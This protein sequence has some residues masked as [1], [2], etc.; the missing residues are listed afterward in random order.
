[1]RLVSQLDRLVVRLVLVALAAGVGAAVIGT[2]LLA[3]S[4]RQ[5]L[6][7]DV[8][9]QHR[10]MAVDVATRSDAQID[11]VVSTLEVVATRERIGVLGPDSAGELAAVLRVSDRFDELVLR[12]ISGAAVSAAAAR[13]LATPEDFPV[14]PTVG[15]AAARGPVVRLSQTTPGVVEIAVPVERPPG[16]TVGTLVASAPLE[17]LLHGVFRAPTEGE[18]LRYLIDKSGTVLVHPNRDLVVNRETVDIAGLDDLE[19]A[20]VVADDDEDVLRAAAPVSSFDAIVVV[21]EEEAV[22][23]AP[24]DERVAELVTILIAV[25]GSAVLAISVAGGYLLRPLSPLAS[26]IAQLGRGHRGL[27]VGATGSGEVAS[28]TTEFNRLADALE[29]REREVEELQRVSLLLH[30]HAA[31]SDV[32]AEVISGASAVLDASAAELWEVDSGGTPVPAGASPLAAAHPGAHELA[33]AAL[34]AVTPRVGPADSSLGAFPVSGLDERPFAVI[35]VARET[36]WDERGLQ[37][38]DALAAVAGVAIENVRRLELE[39]KLAEELQAAADRRRDFM[40]TVTHEFRTP[41]TCI[42]G[43]SS[44]LLEQWEAHDDE[45]RRVLVEKIHRHSEELDELVSRLLDFAVTER[46]T[47][48]AQ[49]TTVE[50][51]ALVNDVVAQLSPL[52]SGRPLARNV[53]PLTVEA[54]AVL[55]RR[56]LTNLISNAVKYSEPGSRIDIRALDEGDMVCVEIEDRGIGMTEEE[57]EKAFTPFWRAGNPTTRGTRGAGIGL[58]LVAEYVRSMGGSAGVRSR[59]GEGSVFFFTLRH[60]AAA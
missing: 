33:N 8:N 42:E 43:F 32:V 14:D 21:E 18:P 15:A 37:M 30:A 13:F 40:G 34:G 47:L 44:L 12:D 55:L 51:Q 46:G 35:V 1:M 9:R 7:E 4:G 54:D 10:D 3:S 59:P 24:V 29:R 11:A 50:L 45:E 22:A 58:S 28:L 26:S 49:L 56:T 27:R 17:V 5:N 23:L 2:A 38:G 52:L 6:R 16:N 41:L 31:R 53:E 39:R 48:S 19:P 20:G 25:I 57:V 60:A 36:P